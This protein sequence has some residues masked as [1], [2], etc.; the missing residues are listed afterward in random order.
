MK[1]KLTISSSRARAS[2][3]NWAKLHKM[4]DDEIDLSDIPMLDKH[5]WQQAHVVMPKKKKPVSLRVDE[6]VLAW[7]K[8]QGPGYQSRMLAVL[9]SYVQSQ[10]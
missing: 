2:K 4:Q 3:T 6:D 9:R 1:K 5:F 7:F 10:R 8:T